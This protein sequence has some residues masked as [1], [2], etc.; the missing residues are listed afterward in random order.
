MKN[1]TKYLSDYIEFL[2]FLQS[3]ICKRILVSNKLKIQVEIGKHL[4]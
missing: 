3:D 1:S 4:L 2:D